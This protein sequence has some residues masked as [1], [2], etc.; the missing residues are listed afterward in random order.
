MSQTT[1]SKILRAIIVQII[2]LGSDVEKAREECAELVRLI[3]TLRGMV[4][5]SIFQKR[6][7]PSASSYLG[8]GKLKE[9]AKMSKQLGIDV[10]IANDMLKPTQINN[11]NIALPCLVWDRTDV[12][13]KIFEY[14]AKTQEAKLQVQLAQYKN[15]FPRLYGKGAELS[16]IVGGKKGYTRGPGEKLLEQRKRYFRRRIDE[17]ESKIDKLRQNRQTQRKLRQRKQYISIALVGYTNSGKSS[18]LRALTHKENVYVADELFATL[19]T[20]ISSWYIPDID[21]KITLA[22]TIGFLSNLPPFLFSSFMATL[23]EIQE[24]D[25]LVHVVDASDSQ[26]LEKIAVV[27]DILQ[28]LSVGEKPSILALNKSDLI[29]P[30]IQESLL[31]QLDHPHTLLVSA[32][33][34]QGF[35]GL[36]KKIKLLIQQIR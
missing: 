19:D 25:I 13:L 29:T 28:Q 30:L 3:E 32:V 35:S 12:I 14:H 27:E 18:L 11:M 2:P 5:V 23:E 9:I 36:Q 31:Q 20:S 4:V 22:D 33:A 34:Q 10:V 6:G 17:L 15:E 1:E 8:S 26:M 7:R 24:A 21:Q 16:Q